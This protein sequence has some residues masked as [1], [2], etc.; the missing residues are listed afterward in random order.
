MWIE[1]LTQNTPKCQEESVVGDQ[2]YE[3]CPILEAVVLLGCILMFGLA[4][5]HLDKGW[6]TKHIFIFKEVPNVIIRVPNEY[7][8]PLVFTTQKRR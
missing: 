7:G 8:A 1:T 5:Q 3:L 2:Q 6:L 4:D